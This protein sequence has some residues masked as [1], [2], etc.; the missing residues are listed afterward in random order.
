MGLSCRPSPL[1]RRQASL[2]SPHI[3]HHLLTLDSAPETCSA[4]LL[5]ADDTAWLEL[6]SGRKVNFSPVTEY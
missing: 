5:E 4:E 3:L 2:I 6:G 1:I